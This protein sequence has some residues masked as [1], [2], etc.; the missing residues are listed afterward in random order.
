[1]YKVSTNPIIQSKN[2]SISHV[3]S[4]SSYTWQYVIQ[5]GPYFD[6][7]W[8]SIWN[9]I[10]TFKNYFPYYKVDSWWSCIQGLYLIGFLSNS[11][12]KKWATVSCQSNWKLR[13]WW[14]EERRVQWDTIDSRGLILKLRYK[15]H[16]IDY[17]EINI[18]FLL[19]LNI[20]WAHGLVCCK[21][22]N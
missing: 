15:V 17:N 3:P 14:G 16:V 2:L 11:R 9:K 13:T 20:R 7:R 4:P 22:I 19:K 1:M 6:N 8:Q 12:A 5:F 21:L 18:I 10:F